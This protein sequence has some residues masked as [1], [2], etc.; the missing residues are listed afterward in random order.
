[1]SELKL[2]PFCGREAGLVFAEVLPTM[3]GANGR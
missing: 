3:W 1:M 2:C